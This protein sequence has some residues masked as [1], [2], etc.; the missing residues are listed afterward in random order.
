MFTKPHSINILICLEMAG[1]VGTDEI[2]VIEGIFYLLIGSVEQANT[3]GP[4]SH[5]IVLGLHGTHPFYN[6]L[7]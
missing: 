7:G 6:L 4:L 1:D 3:N 5:V 2:S